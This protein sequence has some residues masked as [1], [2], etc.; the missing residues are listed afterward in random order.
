[1]TGLSKCRPLNRS[2]YFFAF[3]AFEQVT[4]MELVLWRNPK[5]SR[6]HHCPVLCWV[7][8]R[9]LSATWKHFHSFQEFDLHDKRKHAY[10]CYRVYLFL[11][12]LLNIFQVQFQW[13]TLW[14][15]FFGDKYILELSR[16]LRSVLLGVLGGSSEFHHT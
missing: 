5:S 14:L 6:L 15:H 4:S 8:L 11:T 13:L 12:Y 9:L 7:A 16:N 10:V 3:L 2:F 1:M